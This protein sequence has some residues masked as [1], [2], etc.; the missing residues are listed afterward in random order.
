MI[1]AVYAKVVLHKSP[2][3][4][5]ALLIV[6][7]FFSG[8]VLFFLGVIGEYVGRIY[9]ETKARPQYIVGRTVGLKKD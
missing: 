2:Q 9:E 7:T 8:I 6:V 4:F 5:T 3:G 1:Y